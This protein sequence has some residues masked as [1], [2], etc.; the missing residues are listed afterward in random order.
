MT[1]R[2]RA[3]TIVAASLVLLAGDGRLAHAQT[4]A[5]VPL[6]PGLTIVL[7]AHNTTPAGAPQTVKGVAQGDY[8][9]VVAIT[10]ISAAGID[11]STHLEG[12]DEQ[13]KPINVLISRHVRAADLATSRTQILGFHTQDAGE[14]PGTTSLGPSLA[15]VRD[16]RTTGR[17]NYSVLNFFG[18]ATSTGTLTRVGTT[19]VPFPVLLN[20]RRTTLPAIR[21][22]GLL[23]YGDKVAVGRTPSRRSIASTHLAVCLWRRRRERAVH[24]RVHPR[25][26][27]D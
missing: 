18:Q 27:A 11:E 10:G 6:V 2:F 23:K 16:L 4:P 1:R 7:A 24:T 9:L 3:L 25:D 20:G 17:A 15:V 21:V 14:L 12:V 26:R 13:Q 19:A 22:S 5:V 8:E